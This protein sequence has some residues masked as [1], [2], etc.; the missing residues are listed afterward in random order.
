MKTPRIT[1]EQWAALRAVVETGTHAMAAE[2][3]NKSQSTI[4]YAI[5][6]LED[7]LP[8]DVFQM[9]GRKA[10]L[11]EEGKI[12]YR[13]AVEILDR[14]YEAESVAAHLAKGWES[15]VT[16][17]VDVIANLKPL[18]I[19][20][21]KLAEV[22]PQ[23]RVR[24]LE[25]SLSGTDEALLDGRATLV[26]TS[27]VP[28]GYNGTFLNTIRMLPVVH[29]RHPLAQKERITDEDLRHHLQVVLRDS[30]TKREQNSGWLGSEKR[31]T[32]SHFATS[33]KILREGLGF[34]FIPESII[35]ED[36]AS[37]ELVQLDIAWQSHREIALYLVVNMALEARPAA[38]LLAREI[39]RVSG[40]ITSI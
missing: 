39:I 33:R 37:G 36:L 22:S 5:Q 21:Q 2:A 3:L 8:V 29:H 26:I 10:E 6:K 16:L 30:G 17:A 31:W 19:A 38:E 15:E 28:P 12:L 1:I 11:T 4:S 14:A 32:V 13:R 18:L 27:R 34:A 9:R 20:F 35:E 7:Q 40:N 23:T 24:V 25:T